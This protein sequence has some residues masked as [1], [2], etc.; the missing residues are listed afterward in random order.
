MPILRY[1]VVVAPLLLGLLYLAEAKL[2]PPPERLNNST[3]FYGL[4]QPAPARAAATTMAVI[5]AP[6]PDMNSPSVRAA[7]PSHEPVT[8]ASIASPA[9]EAKVALA[10]KPEPK[11]K[12]KK[13]VRRQDYR[14][15]NFAQAQPWQWHFNQTRVW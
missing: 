6:E 4:P 13:V 10:A 15:N 3:T 11:K 9:P 2:P 8:T 12:A 1:F 5:W 7:A 14:H